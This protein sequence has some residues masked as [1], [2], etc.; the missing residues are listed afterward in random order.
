MATT[1]ARVQSAIRL[2]LRGNTEQEAA[3]KLR[4]RE[5]TSEGNALRAA[6]IAARAV[7]AGDLMPRLRISASTGDI[8]SETGEIPLFESGHAAIPHGPLP[9]GITQYIGYVETGGRYRTFSVR[10]RGVLTPEAL[11]A[12]V[13][14]GVSLADEQGRYQR[15]MEMLLEEGVD[16]TIVVE[17]AVRGRSALRDLATTSQDWPPAAEGPR[18]PPLPPQDVMEAV[19]QAVAKLHPEATGREKLQIGRDMLSEYWANVRHGE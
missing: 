11:A 1:L 14:E 7:F 13:T 4:I 19:W 6:R 15:L 2:L 5:D 12:R 10:A 8:V 18:Q 16:V 9:D 3:D 17:A